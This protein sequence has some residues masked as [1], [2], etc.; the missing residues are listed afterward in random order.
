MKAFINGLRQGRIA[1]WSR[2]AAMLTVLLVWASPT[3]AGVK[4][5][6]E[7]DGFFYDGVPGQWSVT[8]SGNIHID[9]MLT[10]V[11]M[12]SDNPLLNGRLT[13]VGNI[14]ADAEFNGVG[15]GTGVFEVGTW[16]FNSESEEWEFTAD[17]KNSIW[18]TKWE[19]GGNL[20]VSYE[21][22]VIGHGIAGEVEGMQFSVIALGGGG[23]ESYIGQLL[24]PHAQK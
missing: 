5:D 1:R 4:W 16:E 11:R 15:S 3:A 22:K 2:W 19:A 8:P 12:I 13:W 23:V 21:V 7:I 24:D 14:N 18:V 10:V 17:Q 6:A 9:G 20:L